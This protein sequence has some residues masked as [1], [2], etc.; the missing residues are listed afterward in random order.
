ML[1]LSRSRPPAPTFVRV[2]PRSRSRSLAASGRRGAQRTTRPPLLS[3]PRLEVDHSPLDVGSN[4][5]LPCSSYCEL[6][7]NIGPQA[8]ERAGCFAV[9]L[10][11]VPAPVAAAVTKVHRQDS[12]RARNGKRGHAGKGS[13]SADAPRLAG[14]EASCKSQA[15][16]AF[17]PLPSL[18]PPPQALRIPTIGIG[19]GP[20]TSGQVLVYH[21]LLGM[22]SHPHHQK[23][24]QKPAF[25]CL[26]FALLFCFFSS[27]LSAFCC[28]PRPPRRAARSRR[29]AGA[30]CMMY[31]SR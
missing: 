13:A 23:A 16:C 4:R 20:E 10:E 3:K 9:V 24:R 21:D 18:L 14:E 25:Y 7:R 5:L 8:L 30:C 17:P 6:K 15:V 12:R 26:L 31:A 27:L 1:R 19:A 11:C 29:A 22:M 2:N 28:L